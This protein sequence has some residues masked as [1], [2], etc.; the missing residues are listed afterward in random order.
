MGLF[1]K[2]QDA[3]EA[4]PQEQRKAEVEDIMQKYKEKL[5]KNLQMAPIEQEI[6]NGEAPVTTEDYQSFKSQYLPPHMSLYERAC[7][8][9][10]KLLKATPDKKKIPDYEE[11]IRICH[12]NVTPAGVTSLSILVPLLIALLGAIVSFILFG[13]LFFTLFFLIAGIILMPILQRMPFAMANSWRMKASNQMVLCIFYV[14]MYMRHTSNLERAIEF[15][16]KHLAAPLSVDLRK[17]LWDVETETYSTVQESLDSYLLTWKKWNIEFIESFHLVQSSLYETSEDRRLELLDK[18]LST[19]LDE[20]YE[21]MLHYAQNLKSPITMLNMLGIILPILGLVILPLVVSFMCQVSWVHLAALYNIGLPL[22]VFYLSRSVLSSRP[23]GYGDTDI[24]ETNPELQKY[25]NILFKI[26]KSEIK[27]NPA[28]ASIIV[29]AVFILIGISPLLMHL[30]TGESK[31]DL[32]I[33]ITRTAGDSFVMPVNEYSSKNEKFSLLGYKE[34]VG[35]PPGE[36]GVGN[37]IGPFGLGAGFL[38]LM[39]ILGLGIG[40]GMYYR[41]RSKN[42]IKIRDRAKQLESEFASALF[43]LGNRI[44]DGIPAEIAFSKVAETVRGTESGAFFDLVSSNISRLGMSVE[45]AI[46]DPQHGAIQNFPSKII[47]SSMKVLVESSRKGPTIAAQALVNVSRYIKE[48]HRVNERLKDLMA[49]IVSSIKSQINFLTPV[50]AGIVIG[51]T[52]MITTILSNLGTQLRGINAEAGDAAG[53]GTSLL[54]QFGDGIPT[55]Y[56]QIVVGIYVVQIIY[57]LTII[58]NGIENGADSLNERYLLG[59]NMIRSTIMYVLISFSVM[60]LFNV[61]AGNIIGR[62]AIG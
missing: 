12:L 41:L 49:E 56:F 42:V 32:I 47:E 17:V 34:S 20:T 21:N 60:F 59:R 11:A 57:V 53:A 13:S 2:K 30:A 61:I 52:S 27:L 62:I 29:M 16:S 48:I 35:C 18:S 3:K 31:W 46:F 44:G 40:I 55:F 43:Q 26:G 14:V 38:S 24:A 23:T 19:I 10:E 50:I 58:N 6:R 15:A 22:L 1:T 8:I 37:L 33:P 9:C 7:N 28:I 39:V 54:S 5:D 36:E 45:Q 4:T 51:I 25:R